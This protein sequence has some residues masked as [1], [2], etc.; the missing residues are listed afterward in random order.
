MGDARSHLAPQR[1]VFNREMLARAFGDR[2]SDADLDRAIALLSA[3]DGRFPPS[4]RDMPAELV[5]AIQ[6][7]R[8]LVGM[9]IAVNDVG[10]QALTVEDVLGHAVTSRPTFYIYFKDKEDCFLAAFDVAAQRMAAEVSSVAKAGDGSRL[11]RLRGGLRA[12]LRFAG[13]A[14]SGSPGARRGPRVEHGGPP[15]A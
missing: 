4:V 14:G 3:N 8:L 9:R 11:E 7:E 12:L 6:R 5:S 15:P 2:W 13:G 1:I 10:Y